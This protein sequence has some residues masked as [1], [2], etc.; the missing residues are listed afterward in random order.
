[1]LCRVSCSSVMLCFRAGA[2]VLGKLRGSGSCGSIPFAVQP[3][4]PALLLAAHLVR[5]AARLR[6]PEVWPY[7]FPEFQARGSSQD[8]PAPAQ[9]YLSPQEVQSACRP[10]C[11]TWLG[12]MSC[13]CI[14]RLQ[15]WHQ[16]GRKREGLGGAHAAASAC[17]G[18]Q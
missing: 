15:E 12:A 18:G 5:N 14:G 11:C 1:M 10:I 6:W 8:E 3:E 13:S 4:A 9:Y 17:A 2:P 16:Q 7:V